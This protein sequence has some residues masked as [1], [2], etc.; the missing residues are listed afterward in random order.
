MKR[1][2]S[3]VCVVRFV[4]DTEGKVTN[5]TLQKSSG[6]ELD[7]EV[8]QIF[9]SSPVW[10]PAIQHNRRV[11]AYRRQPVKFILE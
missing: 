3:G 8:L 4:I 9:Q 11:K 6:T 10:I 7:K 5:V 1:N 2:A